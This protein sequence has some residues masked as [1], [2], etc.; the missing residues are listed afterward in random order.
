MTLD[1]VQAV[2]PQKYVNSKGIYDHYKWAVGT[3]AG[4][5]DKQA[6]KNVGLNSRV[7]ASDLKLDDVNSCYITLRACITDDSYDEVSVKAHALKGQHCV[8]GRLVV[9]DGFVTINRGDNIR[10]FFEHAEEAEE[11][12]VAII[13]FIISFLSL[14][15]CLHVSYICKRFQDDESVDKDGNELDGECSRPQKHAKS[16]E[17]AR[18]F[19]LDAATVIFKEQVYIII[20]DEINYFS[21]FSDLQ[22]FYLPFC[23]KKTI[24]HVK[25]EK[26]LHVLDQY[27]MWHLI[28]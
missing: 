8:H 21:L 7:K 18:E 11:E 3:G 6:F 25:K 10:R 16:P 14:I 5:S 24:N 27:V 12:E 13:F 22:S 19:L 9:G 2:W 17:L 23:C 1:T 20:Y 26:Q 4:K 28:Q 15:F